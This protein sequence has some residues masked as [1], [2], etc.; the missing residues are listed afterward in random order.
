L[1]VVDENSGGS[2]VEMVAGEQVM[3]LECFAGEGCSWVYGGWLFMVVG[4]AKTERGK[5]GDARCVVWV[6]W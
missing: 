6:S 5:D 2:D 1:V 4:D 3:I